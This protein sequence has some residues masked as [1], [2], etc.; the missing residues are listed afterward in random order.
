MLAQRRRAIKLAHQ[1]RQQNA[2]VRAAIRE[3]EIDGFLLLAGAYGPLEPVIA[4]W[5][6]E[7]LVRLMPRIGK[8]RGFVAMSMLHLGPD[9]R[10]EQLSPEQR[11]A[12]VETLRKLAGQA[13]A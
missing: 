6:L 1:R 10:I 3:G 2:K 8:Q 5:K 12:L 11:Q 13:M 9:M 7:P 4:N